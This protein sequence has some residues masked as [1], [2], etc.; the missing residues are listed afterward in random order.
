MTTV[1]SNANLIKCGHGKR[2][3]SDVHHSNQTEIKQNENICMLSN[4][5]FVQI[6]HFFEHF[7]STG[8]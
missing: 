4:F 5:I 7:Y 8:I 2:K 1:L 6:D 3:S